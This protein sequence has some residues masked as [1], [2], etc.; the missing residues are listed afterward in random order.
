VKR[1]IYI[2]EGIHDEDKLKQID[3]NINVISIGGF[4]FNKDKLSLIK[5]LSKDNHII[6]LFD[7]DSAGE[8]IRNKMMKILEGTNVS[9]IYVDKNFSISKNK[10]K[11]GIEHIDVN[12][13]KEYIKY[14]IP[15]KNTNY[16]ITYSDIFMLGLSG[17]DST[18]LRDKLC[19]F[20]HIG[21][22]NSKQFVNRLNM[23]GISLEELKGKISELS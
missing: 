19:V 22:C 7:P 10:K 1:D 23:L 13:L 9:N 18:S 5:E 17:L 21:K 2:V 11:I 4:S 8:T 14:Q 12:R 3:S 15:T 20:Y 6:L 16:Y